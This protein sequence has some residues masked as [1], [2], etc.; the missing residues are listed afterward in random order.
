[1]DHPVARA[2]RRDAADV[3]LDQAEFGVVRCEQDV[4]RQRQLDPAAVTEA[5]DRGD[6]RLLQRFEIVEAH[7]VLAIVEPEGG[8]IF[9]SAQHG[10]IDA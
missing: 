4:A 1:M 2:A 7:V 5:V 9:F 3:I 8:R 10:E 6:D